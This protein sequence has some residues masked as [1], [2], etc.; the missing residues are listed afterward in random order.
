MMSNNLEIAQSPELQNLPGSM[1][2]R[3]ESRVY[4]NQAIGESPSILGDLEIQ[5]INSRDILA[6]EYVGDLA[7][8]IPTLL[9][10]ITT[11]ISRSRFN[12]LLRSQQQWAAY[13]CAP[14]EPPKISSRHDTYAKWLREYEL[15][16]AHRP[17]TWFAITESG[18]VFGADSPVE[19]VRQA[20]EAGCEVPLVIE[21]PEHNNASEAGL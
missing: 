12:A 5:E 17:E 15:Q 21:K 11:D 19:A 3:M 18:E 1:L 7:Q 8:L 6:S 16:L 20:R 9:G 2:G 14:L 13:I 10:E 4:S